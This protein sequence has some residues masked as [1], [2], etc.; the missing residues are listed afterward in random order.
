MVRVV[1]GDTIDIGWSETMR[2]VGIDSPEDGQPCTDLRGTPLDCGALAT[3]FARAAW[4]GRVARCEWDRTDRNGRAL[5]TCWM[6]GRDLGEWIT[7]EGW[8]LTYRDDP[9][10]ADAEKDAIFAGRGVWAYEM[11]DPAEWRA[12]LRARAA[13]RNAPAE[14]T[15]AI[16][17]N[18]S[19]GGRIYHLPGQRSY[20]PT[21]IDEARGERWFCSESEAQAAGWR[22][23]GGG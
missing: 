4:E 18:V 10:Y 8:A 12:A 6:D 21:R 19:D 16:K 3:A 5:A 23:V 7:L 15:C 11:D 2:L 22:P 20:G 17:G 13:R 14:G 1:D 9:T